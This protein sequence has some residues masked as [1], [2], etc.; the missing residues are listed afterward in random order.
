MEPRPC[1]FCGEMPVQ[2]VEPF[3]KDRFIVFCGNKKCKTRISTGWKKTPEQAVE[4][5]NK[6]V[7]AVTMRGDDNDRR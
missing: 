3:V 2:K 1:P 6:R 5:W 7:A 4:S